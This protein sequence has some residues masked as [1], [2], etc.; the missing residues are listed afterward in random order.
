VGP[1]VSFT[2]SS[3]MNAT[4]KPSTRILH[5]A[6]IFLIRYIHTFKYMHTPIFINKR[7]NK[8]RIG[9]AKKFIRMT[10][11]IYDHALL[12]GILFTW[13]A[14]FLFF[15]INLLKDMV[16]RLLHF[17]NCSRNCVRIIFIL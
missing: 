16:F 17:I 15:K 1:H 7:V 6:F 12:W 5:L 13:F 11:F 2:T 8:I 3:I 10:Y 14:R 4:C 9:E